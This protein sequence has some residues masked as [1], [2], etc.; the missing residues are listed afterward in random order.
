MRQLYDSLGHDCPEIEAARRQTSEQ[1][2]AL[3]QLLAPNGDRPTSTDADVVV[4]GSLARGEWTSKSDVDWTLLIDGQAAPEHRQTAQGIAKRLSE[5]GFPAPGV[6]GTFGNLAFSHDIIHLIGGQSDTNINTTQR[7]LL[8]LESARLDLTPEQRGSEQIS[9]CDRVTRNVLYRYLLDDTN[10]MSPDGVTSRVPRF[11]LNDIVRFWRTM[12]VD[13]AYKG[14]EQAGHKWALRNIKLR[15]SRKLI[16]AS[17]LLMCASGYLSTDARPSTGDRTAQEAVDSMLDELVSFCQLPPLQ[18]VAHALLHYGATETSA[19]LLDA[20]GWFLRMLN[21][22]DKRTH[23]E[24]LAPQDAYNDPVFAEAREQ[25]H[26]FQDALTSL[27][28][29]DHAR[30]AEFTTKYGIF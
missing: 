20:Y 21:D 28:L 27:F 10:L 3:V 6:T 17:G 4:F 5:N 19:T 25:S 23:L 30:L 7:V 8:L 15:M 14:W 1:V 9:A 26:R 24:E 29:R 18:I 22:D 2:D 12:C 11:L 13:F 16:F